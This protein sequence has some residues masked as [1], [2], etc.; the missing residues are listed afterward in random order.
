[1]QYPDESP[2]ESIDQFLDSIKPETMWLELTKEEA[3]VVDW[4]LT[5]HG[6]DFELQ[7]WLEE[8]PMSYLK[9][10]KNAKVLLGDVNGYE[11]TTDELKTLMAIIPISFPVGQQDAGYDL[12]MKL[13][14]IEH[15]EPP[16]EVEDAD[17]KDT[18]KDEAESSPKTTSGTET[19]T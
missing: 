16:Q 9:I 8:G 12:K 5:M 13:Y 11:I 17:S 15:P 14:R 10:G 4:V 19:G 6:W 2:P 1:M 18:S 7:E 3:Y